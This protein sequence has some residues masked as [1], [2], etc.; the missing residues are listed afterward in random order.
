MAMVLIRCPVIDLPVS[1]G[2]FMDESTFESAD[3]H[4][5]DRRLSCPLCQEVHV[6]QKEEAYLV[7][8]EEA[9]LSSSE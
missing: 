6:W 1:T 4:D 3:L 2:F 8:D 9:P 5:E 7:E